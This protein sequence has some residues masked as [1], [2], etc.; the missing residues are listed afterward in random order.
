MKVPYGEGVACRTGPVPCVVDREVGGEALA[1]GDAGWVLSR[2]SALLGTDPVGKWGR[3]YGGGRYGEPAHRPG[4]VRDPRHALKLL[5]REPGG[6]RAAHGR[7]AMG[8][9]GKAKASSR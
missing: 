6:L 3:Q 7:R 5:A 8:R 4:V 9:I 2:E 1:R